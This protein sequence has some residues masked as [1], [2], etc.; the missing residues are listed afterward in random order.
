MT[1]FS[2]GAFVISVLDI[3]PVERALVIAGHHALGDGVVFTVLFVHTLAITVVDIVVVT[4]KR[5]VNLG[6]VG[7]CAVHLEIVG[8]ADRLPH[9]HHNGVA[10]H[11]ITGGVDLTGPVFMVVTAL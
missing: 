10:R 2:V 11:V 6:G 1:D 4:L 3:G 7:V 5:L 8:L 9:R